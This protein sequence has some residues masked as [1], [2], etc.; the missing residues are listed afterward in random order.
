MGSLSA[1]SVTRCLAPDLT[2]GRY[3]HNLPPAFARPTP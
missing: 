3:V 1:S 2:S